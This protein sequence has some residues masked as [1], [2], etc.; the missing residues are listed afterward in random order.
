MFL[1]LQVQ[2]PTKI[3]D[4]WSL[5]KNWTDEAELVSGDATVV[6]HVKNLFENTNALADI[7]QRLVVEAAAPTTPPRSSR[8]STRSSS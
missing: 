3:D 8:S 5:E 7:P 4:Q 6:L 2:L 1:C